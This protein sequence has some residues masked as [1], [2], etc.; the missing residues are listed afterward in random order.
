MGYSQKY[1]IAKG[2]LELLCKLKTPNV[3][4]VSQYHHIYQMY[5]T[6]LVLV[7]KVLVCLPFLP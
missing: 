2:I 6:P 7:Q 3:C 5:Q 1:F 4:T